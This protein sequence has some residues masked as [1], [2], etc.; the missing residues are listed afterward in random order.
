MNDRQVMRSP[1]VHAKPR[2][3]Y[4]RAALGL[5]RRLNGKAPDAI[6]AISNGRIESTKSTLPRMDFGYRLRAL[7]TDSRDALPARVETA[8]ESGNMPLAFGHTALLLAAGH[9]NTQVFAHVD[10]MMMIDA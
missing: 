2:R 6:W 9:M 3:E 10:T 7:D 8:L 1:A 5:D 4:E